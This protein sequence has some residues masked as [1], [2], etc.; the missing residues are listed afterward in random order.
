M[1]TVLDEFQSYMLV[2]VLC[3]LLLSFITADSSCAFLY[4]EQAISR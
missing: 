4:C 1:K 2:M 3:V